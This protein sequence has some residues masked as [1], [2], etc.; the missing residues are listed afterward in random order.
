[1]SRLKVAQI[2]AK[3][4]FGN[5]LRDTINYLL[6]RVDW[7]SFYTEVNKFA[8]ILKALRDNEPK[9]KPILDKWVRTE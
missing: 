7:P 2:G 1:M 4:N 9:V 3:I 5:K 6:D 8:D